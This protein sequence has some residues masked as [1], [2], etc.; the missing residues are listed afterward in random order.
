L[1]EV[2]RRNRGRAELGKRTQERDEGKGK[3][4]G[5]HHRTGVPQKKVTQSK[6]KEINRERQRGA[7]PILIHP[8]AKKKKGG[9]RETQRR[10]KGSRE[11]KSGKA[12][13]WRKPR[14]ARVG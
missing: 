2:S 9:S 4:G 5:I 10:S 11:K 12:K 1:T 8:H 3:K 7:G 6:K 14:K 13:K